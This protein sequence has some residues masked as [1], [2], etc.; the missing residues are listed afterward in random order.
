MRT[1]TLALLAAVLLTGWGSC[2][3]RPNVPKQVTVVVETFKPL[4]AWATEALPKPVATDG[5]VGARV[6]SED[7]RGHVIDLANCHRRLLRRLDAGQAVDRRECDR[8]D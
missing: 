2:E 3:R 8:G 4:P 6:R 7:A 1:L 5:T